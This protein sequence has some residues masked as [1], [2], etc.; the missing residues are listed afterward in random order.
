MVGA[1]VGE[2]SILARAGLAL[3]AAAGGRLVGYEGAYGTRLLTQDAAAPSIGF[4]RGG[5]V[6]PTRLALGREGLG[7]RPSPLLERLLLSR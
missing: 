7:L 1:Q 5:V 2:T 4:G 6:D 3:A